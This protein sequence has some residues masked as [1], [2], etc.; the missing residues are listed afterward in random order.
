[1]IVAVF[2]LV[3]AI[4]AIV[5]GVGYARKANAMRG[6]QMTTGRVVGRDVVAI[7]GD[8]TEGRWGDGGGWTPRITYA[9]SVDG[10]D[11][12][13]DRVAYAPSGLKRSVAERR[14]AAYPDEVLV[15][16]DAADPRDA[17]L[18]RHTPRLG[19]VLVAGGVIAAVCALVGIIAA[20]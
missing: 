11:L 1:V 2:I 14:A 12:T 3:L 9:Y 17:C 18:E 15:W 19:R 5:A 7:T 4:G 6:F 16:Y 10:E 8:R 20:L 13:G